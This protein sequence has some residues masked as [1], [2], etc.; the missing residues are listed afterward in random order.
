MAY[1]NKMRE[2][3]QRTKINNSLEKAR[4]K[5]IRSLMREGL[6]EENQKVFGIL[7]YNSVG[8]LV[9]LGHHDQ[10]LLSPQKQVSI[11]KKQLWS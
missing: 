4:N 1:E 2:Q 7:S 5:A 8:E 10:V 9:S 11:F 3:L 6:L